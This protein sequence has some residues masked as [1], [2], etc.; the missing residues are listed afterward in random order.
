MN[1]TSPPNPPSARRLALRLGLLTLL[2]LAVTVAH[3]ASRQDIGIADSAIQQI[4]AVE[5]FKQ[6]FTPAEQ[7]MS[8]N[9]VIAS[10]LAQGQAVPPFLVS[11]GTGDER[12]G[13]G[14]YNVDIRTDG[15]D[16]VA[17]DIV[18]GGGR[19]TDQDWNEQHV[20]AFVTPDQLLTVASDPNV[21]WIRDAD[22]ATTNV[23]AL[24]S[25]GYI[26]HTANRA[27]ALGVTGAGVRIGVLSDTASPTRVAALI[28]TGDLGADTVVVPGQDGCAAAPAACGG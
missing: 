9:L 7:K 10:R 22:R 20:R 16:I 14:R 18:A 11:Q 12:D 2:L 3:P 17:T 6:T 19:V 13:L 27:V 4:V 28:A 25:Q 21:S 1:R 23:G 24:T 5:Q 15:T 26:S 8:F